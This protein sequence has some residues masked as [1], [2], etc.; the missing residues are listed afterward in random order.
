MS[1]VLLTV[2]AVL[3]VGCDLRQRRLPNLLTLG[4]FTAGLLLTVLTG[5]TALGE[6]PV[7]GWLA[8]GLAMLLTLPAY[9]AHLLGAGDVKLASAI[10]LLT[11]LYPFTLVFAL[12]AFIALG[13]T[14]LARLAWYMPYAQD[15][16]AL[17]GGPAGRT[18]GRARSV[19][20]G[21]ALALALLLLILGQSVGVVG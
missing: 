18:T 17:V 16:A 3:L 12:A 1:G 13:M 11:G 20:F 9:L 4:G 21:A 8:L 6:S 10:A 15:I 2:W 7:S 19:P 14:L 5:Q